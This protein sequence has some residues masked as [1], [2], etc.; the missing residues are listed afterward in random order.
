L[1]LIKAVSLDFMWVKYPYSNLA[2]PNSN[3][4]HLLVEITSHFVSLQ[5]G[6]TSADHM[7]LLIHLG[8]N[9]SHQ[10]GQYYPTYEKLFTNGS[11]WAS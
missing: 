4:N 9:L 8:T 10:L 6:L 1:S 7:A 11:I 2:S 3:Q 5:V